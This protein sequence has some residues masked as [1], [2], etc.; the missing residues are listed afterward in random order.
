MNR[1]RAFYPWVVYVLCVLCVRAA[2]AV[3]LLEEIV[4]QKYDVAADATLS[5][6]NIDGSI[7]VYAAEQAVITIQA[8]KKAYKKERLEGIVVDVK[9]SPN[10]VAITTSL[11]P[12]ANALSDRSGT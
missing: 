3:E 11:P 7:R 2:S 8:I 4:E 1:R 12:R 10:S 6:Q 9:A 5:V